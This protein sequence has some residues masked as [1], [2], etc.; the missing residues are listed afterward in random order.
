MTEQAHTTVTKNSPGRFLG[1]HGGTAPSRAVRSRAST[2]ISGTHT[3]QTQE[4]APARKS[5]CTKINDALDSICAGAHARGRLGGPDRSRFHGQAQ[6][7][8][9]EGG[10]GYHRCVP[11]PFCAL[12]CLSSLAHAQYR[13]V[14]PLHVR[15]SSF[16]DVTTARGVLISSARR[17]VCGG[18][19][20]LHELPQGPKRRQRGL[21][22]C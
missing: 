15:Q 18:Q 1:C 13:F 10:E 4:V 17:S 16:V 12:L 8:G 6:V 5:R 2:A 3:E 14:R 20:F 9:E 21:Q 11:S 19:A 22:P 7:G